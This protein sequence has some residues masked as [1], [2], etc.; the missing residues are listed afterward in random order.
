MKGLGTAF[1]QI[2]GEALKKYGYIKI[3]GKY[4]YYIRVVNNEIV[5]VI[6]FSTR[7]KEK[8]G[9]KEYDVYGGVATVYR[10]CINFNIPVTQNYNWIYANSEFYCKN[11]PYQNNTEIRKKWRTF[12]YREND[13]ESLMESL[14]YALEV[15]EEVMLPILETADTMEHCYEYYETNRVV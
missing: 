2:F 10:H 14:R 9:Y 6:T 1:K 4:P 13:E 7:P 5:H 11:H 3:K 12:S 15:T 8:E